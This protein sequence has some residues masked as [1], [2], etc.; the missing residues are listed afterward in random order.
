MSVQLLRGVVQHYEWGDQQ[1]IPN[2][3]HTEADAR[4]WA[5]LWFGTHRSGP[6]LVKTASGSQPLSSYA[7]ELSFLVKIIAAAKPLSLQT[8]PTDEQAASGYQE[9]NEIGVSLDSPSRIYRDAS[10]KPELLIALTPFEAICGFRP[11]DQ[12]LELCA[13]FGWTELAAHLRDDGLAECVR[14]ALTTGPHQL[15]A[16]L[17]AWAGRLATMYPG[18]GGVLVALLMHHVKLAPGQA[19]FLGAGNAHAYLGGTG[20]EV[21]SSSDNVVRAAFTQK[22]VNVDEF[23]AVAAITPIES[24]IIAPSETTSGVW[25][26]PVA[27]PRFGAQ[28]IEVSGSHHI[29]ATHN[30][31]IIICTQG[32]AGVLTHGQACIL[33][34]GETLSLSGEATLFRTWGTH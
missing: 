10:A 22:N 28:R 31:E 6:S 25:Q 7:G 29:A 20:L 33:R 13:R 34:Q 9:E 32:D 26:Y 16:Q 21:M 18:N 24:P 4:P 5:E 1:A 19:L 17:P 12:T 14:W 3:L 15:P 2:F 27:T 23:L 11:L 8:H 30:A